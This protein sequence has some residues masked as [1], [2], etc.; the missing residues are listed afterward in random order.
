MYKEELSVISQAILNE[1]EGFEFYNMAA[2]QADTAGTKEAFTELANEE[3][4]HAD[5][6]KKLWKKLSDGNEFEIEDIIESGIDIPSPEIYRWDKVDKSSTSVA[7]SIFGIG[8]QME[9]S[10]IDFYEEA[11][12]KL[13]SKASKD[14]IDLLISWEKVHLDQFSK[15][16]SLLKEDWWSEQGF[17]P[18]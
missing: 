17:A 5:Y 10:S 3:L 14:L 11:K 6:L 7:M 1:I 18:F 12:N 4:K 13:T 16:Y 9:Q 15:Q 2:A 8:M